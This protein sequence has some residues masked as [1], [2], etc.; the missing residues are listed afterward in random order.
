MD[1]GNPRGKRLR[2]CVD[3]ATGC[4]LTVFALVELKADNTIVIVE[5]FDGPPTDEVIAKALSDVS[6]RTADVS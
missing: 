6:T 3:V 1:A 2:R 4:D 5:V